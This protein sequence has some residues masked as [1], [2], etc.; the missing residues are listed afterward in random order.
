MKKTILLI[1]VLFS[2]AISGCTDNDA[3]KPIG[4][5][6][7]EHGCLGSAG[8]TWCDSLQ[9][10]LRTWEEP[11]PGMVTN[12]KE[13][14]ALGYPLMESY[15]RQCRTPEG[16]TFTEDIE[17][18]THD[19]PAQGQ[20]IETAKEYVMNMKPY[21]EDNGRNLNVNSVVQIKCPGC[22]QVVLQ[23]DADLGKPTDVYTN[24]R[25]TVNVTLN[26][27]KVVNVV[28]GRGSVIVLSP[29][30]CIAKGG[31]TLNI[32]SGAI[33]DINETKI[34]E[35]KG[36]ISPNICCIPKDSEECIRKDSGEH[37]NLGEARQIA[38]AS[39]CAEEANLTDRY[40][41]NSYTGTWWIDLE[42]KKE[43][44]SPACVINVATKTAEINWR[45]T[46][47]LP[48]G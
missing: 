44:C 38:L 27:W 16:E 41:C 23:Y 30:E 33:C 46:G 40:L 11:C 9:K 31:R 25:I 18:P 29:E 6:T 39:E 2:V 32:V 20:A 45:C 13:C 22:W 37:M 28:S 35:V 47:V 19:D 48:P 1:V 12:F 5:E 10:C 4:G 15:P 43:G 26:N 3:D 34:G 14:A 36:F 24:D 21:V 17:Q 7:D 42:I 8:Y